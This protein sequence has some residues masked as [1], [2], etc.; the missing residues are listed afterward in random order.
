MAGSSRYGVM[1]CSILSNSITGNS[2]GSSI[3]GGTISYVG[4]LIQGNNFGLQ[5]GGTQ[6]ITNNLIFGNV[7]YDLQNNGAVTQ[8]ADGNYWGEPTTTEL[9]NGVR[10]L[11]KIYDSRDQV[12]LGQVVIHTWDATPNGVLVAP[13]IAIQPQNLAAP[14]GGGAAF[15]VLAGGSPPLFYQWTRDGAPVLHATNFS[16]ALGT[17]TTTNLGGYQVVITNSYGSVTSVLAT[18]TQAVAASVPVL[19]AQLFAGLTLG[20]EVGRN[21]T[22]QYTFDLHPGAG[23]INWT[24]LTTLVLPSSPFTYIDLT[25]PVDR[26]RFYR[27]FLSP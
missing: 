23:L 7:T 6:V 22:I 2:V 11:T 12:G 9:A 14:L 5:A 16:L 17:V 20:G 26:P 8:I 10:N 1:N 13:S 19:G 18:L 21:Y 15:S 25:A 3:S 24:A 27:A 4:N